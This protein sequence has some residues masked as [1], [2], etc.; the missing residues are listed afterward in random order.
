MRRLV[1]RLREGF[2]LIE[3][4]VVIA[5]IAI[6]IALLVPAVQKVREAAARTQ[7]TNNL[8]QLALAVHAYHDTYKVI[9]QN[10]G[11]RQG[12]GAG[13]ASWSWIAMI[14]PYIEQGTLYNAANLSQML[15]APSAADPRLNQYQNGAGTGVLAINTPI[16]LLRCPSDPDAGTLSWTDRADLGGTAVAVSNYKG[17]SGQNWGW[18]NA[19]WNPIPGVGSNNGNLNGLEAG[20]GILFRSNGPGAGGVQKKFTL[21]SVTDGTSNTFMIGEA[22][23]KYCLWTGAWAYANNVTGDCGIFPNNQITGG[24]TNAGDWPNCYNF[25]SPHPNGLQFALCDASVHFIPNN[26]SIQTYRAAATIQGNEQLN[27]TSFE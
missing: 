18:G 20:D 2:T 19:L 25:N 3:L 16:P 17:V 9:P 4:L 5:I 27:L 1:R 24:W 7:C 14:L 15:A 22:Q 11:G 8:K 12:W 13:G 26:V 10:Y 6:L 21:L 23:P